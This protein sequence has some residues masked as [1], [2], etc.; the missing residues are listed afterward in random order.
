MTRFVTEMFRV[1]GAVALVE[2]RVLLARR[3]GGWP[4]REVLRQFH[5]VGNRSL[6][7]VTTTLAFVG[8]VLAHQGGY[9]LQRILGDP[10]LMGPAYLQLLV[11]EIAPILTALMVA[12]RYGAATAAEIATMQVT[13][14]IDALRMNAADPIAYLAAP[15]VLAGALATPLLSVLGIVVATVSGAVTADRTFGIPWG[16]FVDFSM[17]HLADLVG[18]LVKAVVFGLYVP[19]V[20]AVAGL[21][22]GGGSGGVG[23]ATTRAVVLASLGV[24]LLDALLGTVFF[25]LGLSG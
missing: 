3:L 14:Q 17:T 20:A 7:L 6:G 10:S 19:A 25:S 9:Q 13:D 1:V 2:R 18:G 8:M 21:E 15:R 22:A 16:A 5:A 24:V 4:E 23:R 12:A 11:R